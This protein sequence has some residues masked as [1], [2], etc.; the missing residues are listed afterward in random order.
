M[1][2]GYLTLADKCPSCGL[3]YDFADSADGPAVFVSF[4]VGLIVV[5]LALAVELNYQPP[6]WLHML[7]WL[8]LI[9]VLGLALLRPVKGLLIAAQYVHKAREGEL[10]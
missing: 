5:G 3:S 2:K 1:F 7:L 6:I 9:I 8:P 4:F 10:D